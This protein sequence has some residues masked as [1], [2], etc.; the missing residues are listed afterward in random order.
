MET[1]PRN[2]LKMPILN[3]QTHINTLN[4]LFLVEFNGTRAENSK[5]QQ[6]LV[7]QHS[8]L[9][10]LRFKGAS[11]AGWKSACLCSWPVPSWMQA[12]SKCL[13]EWQWFLLHC[14]CFS[15]DSTI[16]SEICSA[17]RRTWET[18]HPPG[19]FTAHPR[20]H[21][22]DLPS[23]ISWHPVRKRLFLHSIFCML[24]SH[25]SFRISQSHHF[26]QAV[27]GGVA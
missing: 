20:L 13:T 25:C 1:T 19:T 4:D 10:A 27:K 26:L 21:P 24:W 9:S 7:C 6:P 23:S 14:M 3:K 16:A 11:C 17:N 5:R 2:E 8:C 12:R 18:P 22:K 15:S